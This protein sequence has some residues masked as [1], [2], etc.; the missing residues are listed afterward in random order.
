MFLK[1]MNENKI[2]NYFNK[3]SNY[4]ERFYIESNNLV[5]AILVERKN[6]I[7]NFIFDNFE[8]NVKILDLGGGTGIMS[9]ELIKSGYSVD[10]IDIS[11]NMIQQAKLNYINL[12][13]NIVDNKLI[14]EDFLSKNFSN[15][16][17]IIIAL[18]Y[19]EYQADYE[20]NFNKIYDSLNSNGNLIFNLPIER[21][22]GNLF[23]MS[24]YVNNFTNLFKS[25]PHPG[26]K[27]KKYSEL[28]NLINKFGFKIDLVKD[29]G[30][31][32]IYILN[33]IIPYIIQK[34]ISKFLSLLDK[35]NKIDFLKSNRI[36]FNNK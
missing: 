29:H 14:Y 34:K 23:G 28:I 20:T 19:F 33:K 25:V 12:D 30:Y 10:M 8:K 6:I 5:E 4:W 7:K 3:N 15:K 13:L 22:L 35:D 2:K 26:L 36:F 1:N 18:G 21:N 11:K 17:D 16:Y 31:G 9:S 27:L 24:R 32:D